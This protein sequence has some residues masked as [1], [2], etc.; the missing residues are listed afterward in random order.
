MSCTSFLL[1]CDKHTQAI[2]YYP[3]PPIPTTEEGNSLPWARSRYRLTTTE[4]G[5]NFCNDLT[6]MSES[7]MPSGILRYPRNNGGRPHTTQ[8]ISRGHQK[9]GAC[10]ELPLFNL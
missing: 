8:H 1:L 9:G 10:K 6:I 5:K 7:Q 4:Q 2:Q 3:Y